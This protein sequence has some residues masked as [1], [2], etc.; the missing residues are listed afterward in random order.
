MATEAVL[1]PHVDQ[2]NPNPLNFK[3]GNASG[4]KFGAAKSFKSSNV[5][6]TTPR[7]AL[8]DVGNT[9][10]PAASNS[11][12]GLALKPNKLIGKTPTTTKIFQD[13]T[14][15]PSAKGKPLLQQI[16]SA[17]I[18]QSSKQKTATQTKTAMKPRTKEDQDLT[19]G[20]V[21]YPFTDT[22]GVL[23]RSN[24]ISTI[25][26]NVGALY[27]G[28]QFQ[29]TYSTDCD[30]E[31][32]AADSFHFDDYKRPTTD[33]TCDSLPFERDLD[34]LTPQFDS[35]SLSDIELPPVEIDSLGL[36]LL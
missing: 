19:E 5:P 23:L 12:K 32:N 8:G 3:G 1:R 28:C 27:Y 33:N 16:S 36:G 24:Y 35:F 10:K 13:H 17:G 31:D 30:A 6:L 18:K 34:S 25:L 4:R 2:E 26:K 20:E 21:M 9:L 15:T 29:P 22:D 7:R 14:R 11:R